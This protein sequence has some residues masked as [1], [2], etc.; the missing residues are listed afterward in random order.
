MMKSLYTVKLGT[1]FAFSLPLICWPDADRQRSAQGYY[2]KGMELIAKKDDFGA[3]VSLHSA[4]KFR[5]TGSTCGVRW[6]AL[7]SA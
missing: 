6:S 3:R 4:L 7:R 1:V 2:E 5:R